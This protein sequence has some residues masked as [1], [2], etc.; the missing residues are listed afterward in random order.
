MTK[1]S[2]LLSLAACIGTLFAVSVR[3]LLLPQPPRW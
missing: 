2:K 1:H 3:C